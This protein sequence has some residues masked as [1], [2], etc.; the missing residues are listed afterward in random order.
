MICKI[1][2]NNAEEIFSHK[3]LFKYDVKYFHCKNCGYLF[4]ED[5][6]W[7]E[8]AYNSA[9]NISDTGLM[10]RNIYFQRL[11]SVLLF[12][13][14]DKNAKFLDYAGGYG[15]FTRMMRD[16]GFD[17]YW[18]DKFCDNLLARGFE[19]QHSGV[20]KFEALTAFEVFEHLVNPIDEVQ[21]MLQQSGSIIF[22]TQLLPDV[23]PKPHEWWYYAFDHGQHISIYSKKTLDYLA[24][25]FNMNAY[26]FG[27]IHMISAMKINESRVKLFLKLS[28]IGLFE[29]VKK[30][31]KSLT[32][33]D[34][35][36]LK[37]K[38]K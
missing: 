26:T 38:T 15:I 7:L 6:Y 24:G 31:M 37:E 36:L 2:Q 27:G 20:D 14:F 19:I 10:E 1:C 22:S 28:K 21:K 16:V 30:N 5:P 34:Y 8:E 12:Y 32:I 29:L 3:I 4:T 18:D 35:N 25:K 9:I 33:P 17:F 11:T 23:V 13:F